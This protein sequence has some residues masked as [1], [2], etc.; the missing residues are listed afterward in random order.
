M[1]IDKNRKMNN[2]RY[3]LEPYKGMKT[4]HVCPACDHNK[5]FT[6]YIDS[7]TNEYIHHSVG[8]CDRSDNCGYHYT[9]KQYFQDNNISFDTLEAY[10]IKPKVLVA[11][12]EVNTSFIPFDTFKN[13]LGKDLESNNFVKYLISLF[14]NDATIKLIERYYISTSKLWTGATVFWQI[15]IDK[16][17]RTGKIMLY[18]PVTGKRDKTKNSWVHSALKLTDFNLKQCFFGSHL[19]IDKSKAV[20][21]VESDKTAVLMS[22][23]LPEYIWISS[24]GKEGLNADKFKVLQGRTVILFPD[25]TKNDAKINCFELW[26]KKAD[27]FKNIAHITVSNYLE[28]IATDTEKVEGLDLADYYMKY[29]PVNPVEPVASVEVQKET[30]TFFIEEVAPVTNENW[31][32]EIFE[33]ETFFNSAMLPT[34]PVKLNYCSTITNVALFIESHFA[35]VKFNN[36]N[37]TYLPYLN[38]LQELKI[39][40]KIIK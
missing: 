5:K 16:K 28:N 20:A 33:L 3:I 11:L 4:K 15:D 7:E 36:G 2:H 31:N 32:S 10:S 6:L 24:S 8:R 39:M 30:T 12:K 9:P 13:C 35:T 25:L 18:N 26:S 37:L 38:R 17:I 19:L 27:E 21:I 40:L 23:Y 22:Y 1:D 14:G 34:Q 29:N